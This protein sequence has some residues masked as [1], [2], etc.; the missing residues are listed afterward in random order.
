MR[1]LQNL[2][3]LKADM[4]KK[5]WVIDSFKFKFKKIDYIVLVILFQ[6]GEPKEEFALVQL[7]FLNAKNFDN[8]LLIS[9]NAVRLMTGA[10][11][12]RMFFGIRYRPNLGEILQQFAEELG[13]HIP[14]TVSDSKSKIEKQAIVHTLSKK[15]NEDTNKLYCYAVKR[16]PV[17]IDK[18]TGVRR[19][20]KRSAYNDNKTRLLR[21]PLYKKLG[22]DLTISF[23]YSDDPG[24]DYSDEVIIDNWIKNKAK[25]GS[26]IALY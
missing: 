11:E 23:C 3:P 16:N 26:T 9:A 4:E 2:H 5:G 6:P 21:G 12:L 25:E 19:Q 15:D 18:V 14:E 1:P 7:D 22:K 20:L 10:E 13:Y 17:V 8:H 24:K